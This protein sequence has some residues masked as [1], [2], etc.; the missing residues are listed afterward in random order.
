MPLSSIL[1]HSISSMEQLVTL[2]AIPQDMTAAAVASIDAQ[3]DAV[4]REHEVAIT[5]PIES[6]RRA[7][8]LEAIFDQEAKGPYLVPKRGDLT[9]LKGG[10]KVE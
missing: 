10:S 7:W 2:R 9:L 8:W 4:C 1:Q 6:G 3:L 5:L